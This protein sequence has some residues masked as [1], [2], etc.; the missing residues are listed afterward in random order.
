MLETSKRGG[1]IPLLFRFLQNIMHKHKRN[2][3]IAQNIITF[4]GKNA[5]LPRFF[6]GTEIALLS[7]EQSKKNKN[8]EV[9][10][11]LEERLW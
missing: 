7:S 3:N 4:I 8:K 2:C 10:I 5:V 11:C 1:A 6:V 9:K